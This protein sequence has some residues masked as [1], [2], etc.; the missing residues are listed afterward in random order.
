MAETLT[1]QQK[2]D[3]MWGMLCHLSALL[4]VFGVPLLNV[5]G[6]L[7]VWLLKKNTSTFVDEQGK[8]SLNFQ[9]TATIA[10]LICVPLVFIGIGIFLMIAV[11]IAD[12]VFVIIAS[13]KVNQGENYK[14]PYSL[15]LI[16]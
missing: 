9:L 16:K 5:L 15:N 11:G 4:A 10:F 7:V 2:D 13:I 1:Q 3:R 12:L 14:Y 8:N 6:P